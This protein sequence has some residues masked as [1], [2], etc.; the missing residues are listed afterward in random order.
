MHKSVKN[1]TA[2]DYEKRLLRVLEHIDDNLD[3]A[4]DL[5]EL[6][7][8]ANF[9]PYHFHRI[10]RG[11]VGETLAG[12]VRRRRISKAAL[13]LRQTNQSITEIALNTGFETSESFSKAFKVLVGYSPSR[14]RRNGASVVSA[15][16]L[17]GA[18]LG[19]LAP[20]T[21]GL[22]NFIEQKA[23]KVMFDVEIKTFPDME[24]AYIRHTGS[25]YEVGPTFE[26]AI[27]EVVGQG[28]WREES[29]VIG[30]SWDSPTKVE[31]HMLRCDAGVTIAA[32]QD[33]EEPL[34]Q[35]MVKGGEH[36]VVM[37]KGS[38]EQ[39]ATAFNWL[40]GQWLPHSGREAAPRPPIEI[41]HTD[42]KETK[43]EDL[44]TEIR[45]PLVSQ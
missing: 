22:R 19:W 26:Q 13:K 3:R 16:A 33:V 30:L 24:M 18:R 4:P 20:E 45:I 1:V 8:I 37:L 2:L 17:G 10:F 6:A 25:Y 23:G 39:L 7:A 40:Y 9:S 43:P 34:N 35:Q 29:K 44:L 38:Y 11:M 27:G 15:E 31:E 21:D 12:Y 5:D 41:Y 32:G 14:Y 42:P 28:L 36:A